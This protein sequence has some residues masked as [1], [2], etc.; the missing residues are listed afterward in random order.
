MGRRLGAEFLES[1][2]L[3]AVYQVS[4]DLDTG[5][6]GTLRWAITE[7]NSAAGADSIEFNIGAGGMQSISLLSPLPAITEALTIDASTQPGYSGSPLIELDGSN[8][9]SGSNGLSINSSGSTVRGLIINRFDGT[10]IAVAGLNNVIRENFI[11]TNST[12]L[13]AAANSQAGILVDA[14][15]GNSIINNVI[16][17]NASSGIRI[18]GPATSSNVVNSSFEGGNSGFSSDYSYV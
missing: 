1:R 6:V 9:G 3:L 16:S 13:A 11:G 5:A 2:R 18:S 4:S 10:G 15:A 7:A 17:G 8:A 12:G 14:S